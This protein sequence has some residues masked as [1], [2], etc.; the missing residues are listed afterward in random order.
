VSRR[1][2][3]EDQQLLDD[4]L[5]LLERDHALSDDAK[6]VVCAAMDGD[7]E[8]TDML[9]GTVPT[10]TLPQV[11]EVA[12]VAEPVGAFLKSISVRGF[13]GIGPGAK[14]ELHPSA[15]LTVVCG[16]NGSG[17]SSFSEALELAITGTTYRW[18]N[19]PRTWSGH[20]RNLH[21]GASCAIVVELAEE[22]VGSTR[23]GVTWDD[24]A[25]L[26][27]PT[28]WVQRPGARREN[29]TA[30][31]GWTPAISIYRP[32][33]SY[34]EL[35]GLLEAPPSTLFD[36]LDAILGLDRL[37]EAQKRL[38]A[39]V[40]DLQ[41]PDK[42]AKAAAK[43]LKEHLAK[44]EDERA[45]S[46]LALLRKHSPNLDDAQALATGTT[47]RQPAELAD[48][49]A[50]T[51]LH[52]PPTEAVAAV[53]SNLRK[54]HEAFVDAGTVSVEQAERRADLLHKALEFHRHEGDGKCPV[55]GTGDLDANWRTSA[56][57]EVA[58]ERQEITRR[59]QAR[60]ALETARRAAVALIQSV[61]RP[62]APADHL[63]L[64]TW[65]AA[66]AAWQQWYELPANPEQLNPR[67]TT[68]HRELA[69]T[70]GAVRGEAARLL[71]EREDV[72]A[73]VA[74]QLAEWVRQAKAA[75]DKKP[76]VSRGQSAASFMVEAAKELRRVRLESV[77]QK[78]RE[79]WAALRQDSN[80]DLGAIELKG[81]GNRRH[82]ELRA[83]VDGT[84]AEALGVMSQGELH[85]LAL[86]LFLPRATMP[87]SPFRFIMLDDPI[88]AMDPAKVDGFVRV[89][90]DLAQHRQVIV[91]S[92]DDRLPQVIRQLG[93]DA[94]L[95]EVCRDANSVI[96]ITDC[97]DPAQRYLDDAFALVKDDRLPSDVRARVLPGLCR[98]AAEVASRD[99]YFANRLG[100]GDDRVTVEEAWQNASKTIRKLAL[101]VHGNADTDLGPW[102]DGAPYRRRAHHTITGA[103]HQG[104]TA[105]P[106]EAVRQVERLVQDVRAGR[107]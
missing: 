31:L 69:A 71:A 62:T 47:A 72:W 50:F 66:S 24:D 1:T 86:A 74:V 4:V 80:V 2:R 34:D 27:A 89:L 82:V 63:G 104:L 40:K 106:L 61:P 87:G 53:L 10:T 94:R 64:T 107:K 36:R 38:N 91:L 75:A 81:Q 6:Y 99:R 29:G 55:C 15:G 77:E 18:A 12:P 60:Q 102:L 28:T 5:G 73:P 78:A 17:K 92:H 103:A 44:L 7:A 46:A 59:R 19:K 67:M 83:A 96:S 35:G 43:A 45:T 13:R 14:L 88:Q 9:D 95:V 33:L 101:A 76:I 41:E 51:E 84:E 57:R 70:F 65:P 22:G 49:R 21:D 68:A 20:W 3:D 26:D 97:Q 8:L 16:R 85:A 56:E 30:N 98:M 32:I 11:V 37:G 100:A 39:A 79:I 52:V 25:E 105:S 58:A 90:T 42:Q 23:I 93:V 48:L 54:A